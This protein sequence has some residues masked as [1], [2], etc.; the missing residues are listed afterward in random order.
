MNEPTEPLWSFSIFK[1]TRVTG[2][3]NM[4]VRVEM[5]NVFN[6]RVYGG[7]NTRSE[8]RE[9]RRREHGEPG[10]LPADDA[11]RS[12]VQFLGCELGAV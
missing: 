9:L 10:E 11:G 7:P 8:Q 1:N 4:Q 6:T 12:A 5:F 2:R 3:L